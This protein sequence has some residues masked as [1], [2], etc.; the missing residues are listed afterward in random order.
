MLI[1]SQNKGSAV[2]AFGALMRMF[3]AMVGAIRSTVTG[4]VMR[5]ARVPAPKMMMGNGTKLARVESLS[6]VSSLTS[7]QPGA[8]SMMMS[9]LRVG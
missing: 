2:Q 9:P 5:S 6:C 1:K 3:R 8:T 7:C 4:S